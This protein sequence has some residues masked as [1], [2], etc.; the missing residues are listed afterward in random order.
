M[1]ERRKAG[2]DLDNE[3]VFEMDEVTFRKLV[4]SEFR[5]GKLTMKN[6][7]TS[8]DQNTALTKANIESTA[9]L[10]E[11]FTTAKTGV[12]IFTWSGKNLR[13]VVQ[14]LYPFALLGGAIVAIMHGKW[15]KWD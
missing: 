1:E 13:K 5:H 8:I 11:I 9:Q 4:M 14:F 7:Q 2:R 10:V 6:L 15:P 3:T 12:S